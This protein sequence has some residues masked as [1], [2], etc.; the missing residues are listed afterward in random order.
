MPRRRRLLAIAGWCILPLIVA[1]AFLLGNADIASSAVQLK[2][3]GASI[4]EYYAA[5]G[6]WPTG[7][8]DLTKTSLETRSPHWRQ[9]LDGGAI[10]WLVNQEREGELGNVRDRKGRGERNH[11]LVEVARDQTEAPGGIPFRQQPLVS[12]F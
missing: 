8:G 1:A 10:K 7:P 5:T 12:D 9:L 11:P 2:A 3:V 6:R 4:Y